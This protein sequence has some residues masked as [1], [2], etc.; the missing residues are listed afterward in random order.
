M[1]K[2]VKNI[3]YDEKLGV[4]AYEFDGHVQNFPNHFHD[5][6]VIGIVENG[7]RILTCKNCEYNIILRTIIRACR[8]EMKYSNT[9]VSA[10][11]KN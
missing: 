6:Y 3:C 7:R 2:S 5:Y 11:Q 1:N 8:M 4:E 9:E 10:F